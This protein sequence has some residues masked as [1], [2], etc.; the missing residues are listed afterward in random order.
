[1]ISARWRSMW[2]MKSTSLRIRS[3]MGR[4]AGR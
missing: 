3:I 2:M 4:R 1:M